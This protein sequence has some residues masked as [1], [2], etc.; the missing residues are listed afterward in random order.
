MNAEVKQQWLE[1]LRSGEYKQ[2]QEQL[3]KTGP[4]GDR[5]CCLGVL[6]DLALKAGATKVAK[7]D[8]NTDY[9]EETEE[10]VLVNAFDVWYGDANA[11]SL[12]VTTS[13]EVLPED[14]R[15]WAGLDGDDPI[16]EVDGVEKCLSNLNDNG[17]T[18]EALADIIEEKL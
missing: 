18:F 17:T 7:L 5:F 6:C 14:V 9:D 3:H 13:F 1:A 2:G 15:K 11:A 12:A 16:V 4:E 10:D 8:Q